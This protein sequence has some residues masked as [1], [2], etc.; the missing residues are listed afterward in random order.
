MYMI[1]QKNYNHLFA[2]K[3]MWKAEKIKKI[4]FPRKGT[5]VCK[6]LFITCPAV[7]SKLE[8]TLC[9]RESKSLIIFLFLY[10][11]TDSYIFSLNFSRSKVLPY[12]IYRNVKKWFIFLNCWLFWG[13]IFGDRYHGNGHATEGIDPQ[14]LFYGTTLKL[15]KF[16]KNL[17]LCVPNPIIKCKM[18]TEN[19]YW[20][21]ESC[22]K[23]IYSRTSMA[24]TL[25]ARLPRLFRTHS[26]VPWKKAHSCNVGII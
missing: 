5:C 24:G 11:H 6:H 16:G 2:T 15:I 25:M 7:I 22:C 13:K 3:R 26:W 8:Y 1:S 19:C 20:L 10:Y 21:S 18:V 17:R 4:T 23:S 12:R 9:I 14:L